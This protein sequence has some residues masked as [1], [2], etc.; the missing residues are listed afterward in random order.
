MFEL[1]N[2]KIFFIYSYYVYQFDPRCSYKVCVYKKVYNFL[3]SYNDVAMTE[4]VKSIK[5]SIY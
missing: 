2:L 4:V 1:L 3:G 5:T